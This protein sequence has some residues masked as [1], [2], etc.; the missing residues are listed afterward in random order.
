M[1]PLVRHLPQLH[2]R[3]LA[4]AQETHGWRASAG[5]VGAYPDTP[6]SY[7]RLDERPLRQRPTWS[8]E[9]PTSAIRTSP[10]AVCA[11]RR[12]MLP[13]SQN[14]SEAPVASEGPYASEAPYARRRRTRWPIWRRH[15]SARSGFEAVRRKHHKR[16]PIVGGIGNRGRGRRCRH[17][18]QQRQSVTTGRA[19]AAPGRLPCRETGSGGT[20]WIGPFRF[21]RSDLTRTHGVVFRRP[22]RSRM[23][24]RQ[25][26]QW[27]RG[28]GLS[29]RPQ[30]GHCG[31]PAGPLAERFG[32]STGCELG[33]QVGV[34]ASTPSWVPERSSRGTGM[35]LTLN[36]EILTSNHVVRGATLITVTVVSTGKTYEASV[37]GI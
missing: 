31:G 15:R 16:W 11:G 8:T 6:T 30:S 17:R 18:R 35:V 5:S 27:E 4:A 13:T 26:G 22:R 36:G 7:E 3:V 21:R 14:P 1:H 37:V 19:R 2:K 12:D 10:D 34:V 28:G 33:P 9:P 20:V 24:G 32:G 25:S 29:T 23:G